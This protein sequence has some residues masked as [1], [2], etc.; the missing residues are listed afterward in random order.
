METFVIRITHAQQVT[1]SRAL[2]R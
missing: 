2:L 1:T